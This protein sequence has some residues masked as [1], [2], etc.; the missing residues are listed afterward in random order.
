MDRVIAHASDTGQIPAQ[1]LSALLTWWL[2]GDLELGRGLALA[3]AR[4]AGDPS[5]PP[6][7]EFQ[8]A[9]AALAADLCSVDHIPGWMAGNNAGM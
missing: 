8:A 9:A 4:A 1:A 6:V 2:A 3:A 7:P 5:R